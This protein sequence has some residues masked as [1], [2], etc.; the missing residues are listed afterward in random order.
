M[1]YLD[2]LAYPQPRRSANCTGR[3]LLAS[4][5]S[6]EPHEMREDQPLGLNLAR[7][8]YYAASNAETMSAARSA[9]TSINSS[10]PG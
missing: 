2:L 10:L 1:G 5:I 7:A 4:D 9:P 8:L 3:S 6:G